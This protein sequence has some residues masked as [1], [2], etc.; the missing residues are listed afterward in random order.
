MDVIVY[1]KPHCIECNMV[2]RFLTDH[3][4]SYKVKDCGSRP[5]YLEEVK[6]MGFL[7][8]PVTVI[9]GVPIQ[10]LRTDQLLKELKIAPSN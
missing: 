10:G 9:D 3:G 7:G 8:V 2:K 1:S 4:V 6:E 5:E